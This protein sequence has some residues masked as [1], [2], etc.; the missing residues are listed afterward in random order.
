MLGSS[1]TTTT[2]TTLAAPTRSNC[3]HLAILCPSPLQRDVGRFD[4]TRRR[5][6]DPGGRNSKGG[7]RHWEAHQVCCETGH[8]CSH[9]LFITCLTYPLPQ[10][11]SPPLNAASTW[12]TPRGPNDP[13][14]THR[15]ENPTHRWVLTPTTMIPAKRPGTTRGRNLAHLWV[16]TTTMTS[17]RPAERS[18]TP[19]TNDDDPSL[20]RKTVPRPLLGWNAR[21][22]TR[23]GGCVG[24]RPNPSLGMD[25]DDNVASP[26]EGL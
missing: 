17:A 14:T 13:N 23:A 4:P 22:M 11:H 24:M 3:G 16:G 18:E 19:R 21:V 26:V 6:R 10:H 2:T 9:T 5:R 20:A 7:P 15:D 1:S 25:A 12:Q 8:D